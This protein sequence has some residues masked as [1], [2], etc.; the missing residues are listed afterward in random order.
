MII[1][2]AYPAHRDAV[3]FCDLFGLDVEVIEHLDMVAN[4]TDGRDDDIFATFGGQFSNSVADVGFEPRIGRFAAAALI[5]ERPAAVAQLISN[6][7]S[8][9]LKLL[10]VRRLRGHGDR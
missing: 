7:T 1:R 4:E 2:T 5:G 8:A 9:G 10:H 3:I 6:Q